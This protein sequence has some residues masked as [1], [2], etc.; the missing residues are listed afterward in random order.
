LGRVEEAKAFAGYLL[1]AVREQ[2]PDHS[3]PGYF[4]DLL[5]CERLCLEVLYPPGPSRGVESPV[6][7]YE[8]HRRGFNLAST[9]IG[10]A[11]MNGLG[12]GSPEEAPT[13]TSENLLDARPRLTSRAHVAAM[14]YNMAALYPRLLDGEVAD[15]Q[16]DPCSILIGKVRGALRVRLKRI[17]A[18]TARLLMLCDGTRTLAAIVDEVAA[19]LRLNAADRRAFAAEGARFLAPLI[20]GELI[21]LSL[22]EEDNRRVSGPLDQ[23]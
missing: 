4:T 15:A 2:N 10:E 16:P 6:C 17:N 8:T 20:A 23:A 5:I 19:G 14:R 12:F 3:L 7:T 1:N 22:V 18:P 21:E 11:G 13:R 9:H